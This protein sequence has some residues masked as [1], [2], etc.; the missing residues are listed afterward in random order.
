VEATESWEL[1]EFWE[2]NAG[3]YRKVSFFVWS[4][5]IGVARTAIQGSAFRTSPG[6]RMVL[7]VAV[8]R[9]GSARSRGP[10]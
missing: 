3:T 7:G 4:G 6:G 10:S 1:P 9:I 2:F 5:L 8:I